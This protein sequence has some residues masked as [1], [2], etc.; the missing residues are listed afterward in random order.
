MF[1][2][3]I[4]QTTIQITQQENPFLTVFNVITFRNGGGFDVLLQRNKL[5]FL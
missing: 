1:G 2:G 5:L 3:L 4:Q